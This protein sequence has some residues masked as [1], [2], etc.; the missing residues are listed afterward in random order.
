MALAA[1]SAKNVGLNPA[2][3]RTE[4]FVNDQWRAVAIA[5]RF[6]VRLDR[7]ACPQFEVD[8]SIVTL[9]ALVLV[10]PRYQRGEFI[11]NL[12]HAAIVFGQDDGK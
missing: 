12:N 2:H 5:V 11:A 9:P 1:E 4:R 6:S 7:A 10:Q 3:D 8:L